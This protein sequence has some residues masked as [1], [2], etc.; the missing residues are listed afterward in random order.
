MVNKASFFRRWLHAKAN[1]NHPVVSSEHA[2]RHQS[3]DDLA[4]SDDPPRIGNEIPQ[5]EPLDEK[6]DLADSNATSSHVSPSAHKQEPLPNPDEIENGGSFACFMDQELDPQVQQNALQHLWQQPQ[7]QQLDGLE[8][9]DQDFSNQP[10]LTS[11]EVDKLFAQVY[12]CLLM[13]EQQ[14]PDPQPTP[15]TIHTAGRVQQQSLQQKLQQKLKAE[16][17]QQDN[18][19][20]LRSNDVDLTDQ[21]AIKKD[22]SNSA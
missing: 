11:C 9:C 3:K 20:T 5:A 10:K 19:S 2:N 18:A 15:S 8:Q 13:D 4:R 14:E 6:S 16:P 1:S 12:Q 17:K 7:F 21:V 22:H